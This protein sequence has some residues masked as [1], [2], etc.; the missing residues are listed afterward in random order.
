MYPDLSYLFHDL[1][2]TPADNWLSIFKTFGLLLVL[3]IIAIL[4][5]ML[6]PALASVRNRA[7]SLHCTSNLRN[8]AIEFQLFASGQS[9][10][11]QGDSERLGPNRFRIND[12]LDRM[13]RMDEF[14]DL[15]EHDTDELSSGRSP[16]LCPAGPT[17]LSKRRGL[18]CNQESVSPIEDVSLAFNMRL[19]RGLIRMGDTTLLAPVS[20]TS[21]R[22]DILNHPYVPL[23]MDVDGARAVSAGNAPF[24]TA[25]GRTGSDDPYAHDRFWFP[26]K[27]HGGVTNVAFVGGHVLSR[28]QPELEAWNWQYT[29]TVGH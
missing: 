21:V 24:Y 16:A 5:A 19:H 2:G 15:E 18:P 14:W 3:A 8:T 13:Y 25:P 6:L 26:S 1:F 7:R 29:A 12:F 17:R 27:R 23:V 11:G 22:A 28:C 4:M 9:A 20:V 10:G